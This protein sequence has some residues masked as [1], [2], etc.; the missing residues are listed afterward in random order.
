MIKPFLVA[1][2]AAGLG[3]SAASAAFA[4]TAT[5]PVPLTEQ[6]LSLNSTFAP[7]YGV[8][9]YEGTLTLDI[10]SD[11]IVSGYYRPND[12]EYRQVVGGVTGDQIWLDIGYMG[13]LHITG[14]LDNG[15]IVATTFLN[16]DTYTFSAVPKTAAK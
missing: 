2:L 3:L 15:R 11:G 5:T 10:S 7:D 1:A 14:K 9:V 16:D 6:H 13:R 4:A 8:G 12:E